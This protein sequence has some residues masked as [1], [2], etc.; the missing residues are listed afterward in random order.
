MK[1]LLCVSYPA[2]FD[3][4][5]RRLGSQ[6]LVIETLTDFRNLWNRSKI[7]HFVNSEMYSVCCCSLLTWRCLHFPR[8]AVFPGLCVVSPTGVPCAVCLS[9]HFPCRAV[10]PGLGVVSPTLPCAVCLS[11]HFPCRAG[12]PVLGVVS[13]TLPCAVCLSLVVSP[14]LPYAVCL[15]LH[16]PCRAGFPGLGVVSPT[17]VPCA[18]CLSGG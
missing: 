1:H 12:F 17:G 14:T 2:R 8:R 3:R 13:P 11:L 5:F 9:L 18:V 6:N 7:M 15:S 10:F 4:C 16:F